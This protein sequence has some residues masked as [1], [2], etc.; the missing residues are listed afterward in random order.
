MLIYMYIYI[1]LICCVL[2]ITRY[3]TD[4]QVYQI[5]DTVQCK[6][7]YLSSKGGVLHWVPQSGTVFFYKLSVYV[8]LVLKN[9]C[10]LVAFFGTLYI[11]YTLYRKQSFF[12][13]LPSDNIPMLSIYSSLPS[14]PF[15]M[16]FL[17]VHQGLSTKGSSLFQ[18]CIAADRRP[19]SW[20]GLR[21]K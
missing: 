11:S 2:L 13:V 14:L 21:R 3:Y 9:F 12:A 1:F 18:A 7:V 17:T 6:L 10:C 5:I 16:Y 15:C 4:D 19:L 20:R 8:W